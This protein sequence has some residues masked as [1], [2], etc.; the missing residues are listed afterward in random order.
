MYRLQALRCVVSGS[1]P[2]VLHPV[3]ARTFVAAAVRSRDV[4][5]SFAR[6]EPIQYDEIKAL[7]RQPSDVGPRSV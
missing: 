6:G 4:P 5:R 3:Y 2:L 1:R 7:A